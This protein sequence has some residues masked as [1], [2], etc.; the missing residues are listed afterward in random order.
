MIR[1]QFEEDDENHERWLISYAD[2]ITL[3]FAFFVVMYSVSSVNQGKY[4][5]LSTSINTAFSNKKP[6]QETNNPAA[7]DSQTKPQA[8][9]PIEPP[10]PSSAPTQAQQQEVDAMSSLG[11]NLSNQLSALIKTG[12]ARVIQ[13]NRGLRIDI[14]DSVLFT[15]GSADLIETAKPILSKIAAP[16][17]SSNH[18]LLIE[19]HT[20]NTPIYIT[21]AALFS[22]WELSA[23]RASSVTEMLNALGINNIRLSALGYGPSQPISDNSTPEGRATNRHISIMV[24]YD[25]LNTN[26]GEAIEIA[27]S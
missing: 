19:G 14:K 12:H 21:N 7:T 26:I 2:F 5:E 27:P 17:L 13:N 16:L 25:S 18:A 3:L 24:I 4:K 1:R 20:D 9:K 23:V 8:K 10:L 22:N 6:T 11:Q 15:A